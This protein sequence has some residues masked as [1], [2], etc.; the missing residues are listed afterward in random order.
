MELCNQLPAGGTGMH[1][2]CTSWSGGSSRPTRQSASAGMRTLAFVWFDR[3]WKSVI[4]GW[5]INQISWVSW[6]DA[7][8][9]SSVQPAG[10]RKMAAM[11]ARGEA[12]T[13]PTRDGARGLAWSGQSRSSVAALFRP[14]FSQWWPRPEY[15]AWS[16]L[17]RK[18]FCGRRGWPEAGRAGLQAAGR[19]QGEPA[20]QPAPRHPILTNQQPVDLAR[21]RSR[22]AR[23]RT[24]APLRR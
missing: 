18:C 21:R 24:P 9:V 16:N 3:E 4:W 1:W 10:S 11:F 15:A 8:D 12:S 14:V 17:R 13:R 6:R 5:A 20:F 22:Q 19:L 23:N 7:R 2:A